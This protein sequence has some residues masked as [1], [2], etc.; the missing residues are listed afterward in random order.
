MV[1]DRPV[2][3]LD[4]VNYLRDIPTFRRWSWLANV[5]VYPCTVI[6]FLFFSNVFLDV[7]VEKP[8]AVF[9]GWQCNV[10]REM[11]R[12][13]ILVMLVNVPTWQSMEV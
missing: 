13:V 3:L 9:D 11:A 4:E 8:G 1:G 7:F 2:Q 6:M 10:T 12:F 5:F